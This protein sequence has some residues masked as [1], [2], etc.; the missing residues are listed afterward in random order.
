M[1][2]EGLGGLLRELRTQDG[3]RQ[4]DV[5]TTL[6]ISR[7]SLANMEAGRHVVT[8]DIQARLR[9]A[10]PAWAP[11]LTSGRFIASAVSDNSSFVV[12]NLTIAY[13]FQESRSPSEIIQIRKVR[14]VR[15][16]AERYSLG[17]KRTDGQ[18]LTADTGILWGGFLDDVPSNG[19][20]E[21]VTTVNFGRPLRHGETHE[22]AVRSWV[23]RDAEPSCDL[24]LTMTRPTKTASL[25][26]V[27]A[28]KRAPGQA[29]SYG[30]IPPDS[31]PLSSTDP[32]ANLLEATPDG[33]FSTAFEALKP[34]QQFG[35]SWAW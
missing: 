3:L 1:G 33:N 16:G 18:S 2:N 11:A 10:Y 27:F 32:A 19:S 15:A 20:G 17:L 7:S 6:N 5:A 13:I 24:F 12:D 14:A 8:T 4:E 34:A 9:V 30:P 22:F 31:D 35:V 29:W 21:L 25:H 23:E 26:L 28:G